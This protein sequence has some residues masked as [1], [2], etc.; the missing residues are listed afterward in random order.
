MT[1]TVRTAERLKQ[2]G[3]ETALQK[4]KLSKPCVASTQMF[5]RPKGGQPTRHLFVGNC[6]PSVGIDRA[7][8][9]QIFTEFGPAEVVVPEQRQNP[10]SAFVFV[11]YPTAEH[12][13]AALGALDGK[14]NPAAAGRVFTLKYADLKKDKVRCHCSICSRQ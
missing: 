2:R 12:A 7:A 11:S 1:R 4:R 13:A 6:G 14:A 8:V 10:R 9:N 5:G 3:D